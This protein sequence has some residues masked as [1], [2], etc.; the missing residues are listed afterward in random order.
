MQLLVKTTEC[1]FWLTGPE[2]DCII[3]DM[4]IPWI[5]CYCFFLDLDFTFLFFFFCFCSIQMWKFKFFS[6]LLSFFLPLSYSSF[7]FSFSLLS[8]ILFDT[9]KFMLSSVCQPFFLYFPLSSSAPFLHSF[10]LS[11]PS[12]N[13][14]VTVMVQC[15]KPKLLNKNMWMNTGRFM[16]TYTV[17]ECVCMW[18]SVPPLSH[19]SLGF[20]CAFSLST[21]HMQM[22]VYVRHMHA[23]ARTQ[24]VRHATKHNLEAA[25][26]NGCGEF[27]V[28]ST[29]GQQTWILRHGLESI[30]VL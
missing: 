17:S 12:F 19:P 1:I 23:E 21:F 22:H 7:N 6:P 3:C 2:G 4:L 16:H 25:H 8:F 10:C 24:K 13:H 30:W 20:S 14:I 28:W 18:G 26:G 29:S 11:L 15:L 27:H 9:L 5:C